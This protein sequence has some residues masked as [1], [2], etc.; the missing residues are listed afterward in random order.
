MLYLTAVDTSELKSTC[1]GESIKLSEILLLF[2]VIPLSCSSF[3][4]SMY[5]ILQED[6]KL[7]VYNT[8]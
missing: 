2:I 1:P 7:L 3:L 5:L 4:L 8:N 6:M